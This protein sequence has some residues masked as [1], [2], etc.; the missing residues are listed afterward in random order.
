MRRLVLAAAAALALAGCGGSD[1]RPV[2]ERAE[3]GLARA[4]AVRVH[5]AVHAL[6]SLDRSATIPASELPLD[7]LHV[8]RWTSHPRVFG[9]GHG[10]ECAKADLDAAAAARE[11]GPALPDL[12]FDPA[13]IDSATIE[14]RLDSRGELERIDLRG[15]LSGADL[16]VDLRPA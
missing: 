7:R 4:D 9:C 15:E 5:L 12:P 14:V 13:E 10:F 2:F 6:M 16:E 11:L 1:G 8:T 3:R